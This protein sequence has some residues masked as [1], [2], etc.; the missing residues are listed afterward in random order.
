MEAGLRLRALTRS[1][2]YRGGGLAA[3]R[4]G[5]LRRTRRAGAAT[6][7]SSVFCSLAAGANGNGAAVGPLPLG[8]GV[9]VAH[10]K[11]MLHVVLV[12]P[13]D[14]REYRVHCKDVC[15]IGSWSASCRATRLQ[16]R[17]HETKA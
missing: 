5:R 12:S 11:R 8:S 17:R 9:E 16:G 3:A 4:G 15:S 13:L 2:Y 1:H 14:P 10:A 7:S 6:S